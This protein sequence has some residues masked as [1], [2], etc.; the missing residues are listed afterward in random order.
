MENK[1]KPTKDE[2]LETPELN[3]F[4]LFLISIRGMCTVSGACVQNP[5]PCMSLVS[6][7]LHVYGIW[8]LA[9]VQYPGPYMCSVSGSLHVYSIRVL[10]C[11]QYPGPCMCTVS[12]SFHVYSIRV[13][14][15]VQY[16]GP[17]NY[18]I[19]QIKPLRIWIIISYI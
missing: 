12:G 16:P 15:C 6:G 9:C 2:T 3:L 1:G 14:S 7:S 8:V 19:K 5:G 18:F 11:G 13:L 10:A 17:Y 4:C